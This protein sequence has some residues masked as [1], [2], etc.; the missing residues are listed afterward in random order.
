MKPGK[1]MGLVVICLAAA[2][3]A[4]H[5]TQGKAADA[6]KGRTL[7]V[8]LNYTGAGPVDEKHR[9]FVFLFDSP[10]F[11]QGGAMPTHSQAATAKDGT[12]TFT[13]IGHSP[14]Y[15]SAAYD[16]SGTYD[17]QSGPPP[18]GSPLGMYSKTPGVPEPV[19]IKEGETAQIELAFDDS[20]P[21]P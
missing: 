2:T 12:L 14:V 21:M 15:I 13:D 16:K 9:I 19:N 10:D 11:I 5:V 8:K 3:F 17:G 6:A 20:F 7:K 1:M 18:S 4:G